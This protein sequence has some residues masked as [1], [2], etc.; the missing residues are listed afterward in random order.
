MPANL[1]AYYHIDIG[2]RVV[3]IFLMDSDLNF[4]TSILDQIKND[5]DLAYYL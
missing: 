5:L 1:A 4:E 2:V 3:L